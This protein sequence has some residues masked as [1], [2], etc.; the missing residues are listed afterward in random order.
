MLERHPDLFRQ[1]MEYEKINPETGER[2]TWI[3]NES[4]AELSRP[5]RVA[6][7]KA[8]HA[9]QQ[10]YAKRNQAHLKL[11]DVFETNDKDETSFSI[12][13]DVLPNL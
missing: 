1:A 2:F 13:T 6:A 4:L 10:L 9:K 3:Q 5:E 8:Q 12:P 7:I 11:K